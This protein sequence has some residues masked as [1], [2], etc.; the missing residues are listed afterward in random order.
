MNWLLLLIGEDEP[1]LSE[2]ETVTAK[3]LETVFPTPKKSMRVKQR[4]AKQLSS[5]KRQ[6]NL[7]RTEVIDCPYSYV[8]NF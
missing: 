2:E 1:T 8:D 3:P 7:N 5:A 6:S 4:A